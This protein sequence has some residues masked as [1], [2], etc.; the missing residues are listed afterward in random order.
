MYLLKGW[1]NS[2]P[3]E[4]VAFC[5]SSKWRWLVKV[6]P[7][8]TA[9]GLVFSII[10][11]ICLSVSDWLGRDKVRW[12]EILPVLSFPI[13]TIY[14]MLPVTYYHSFIKPKKMMRKVDEFM[15]AYLP[16]V[17]PTS[18][19]W[20]DKKE[21][22]WKGTLFALWYYNGHE[23]KYPDRKTPLVKRE[24]VE[25][26]MRFEPEEDAGIFD[27]K[28]NYAEEFVSDFLVF[29]KGKTV[30]NDI[31]VRGKTLCLNLDLKAFRKSP[32]ELGASIDMLIYIAK[33]FHLVPKSDKQGRAVADK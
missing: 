1:Q 9:V 6:V 8:L 32:Y 26:I 7:P 30:C 10:L 29:C 22:E 23:Q 2:S 25:I 19:I 18:E 15:A 33:R 21:F 13:I 5:F 24:R 17:V 14:I 4:D 31:M 3:S 27:E 20:P 11:L 16:D 28:G 12:G